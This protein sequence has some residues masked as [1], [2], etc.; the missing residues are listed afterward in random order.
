MWRRGAAELKTEVL[1]RQ[2]RSSL[3]ADRL[4]VRRRNAGPYRWLID[5]NR[6][7]NSAGAF[8]EFREMLRMNTVLLACSTL[9]VAPR[10]V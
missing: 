1:R 4:R 8:A 9:L 7:A 6:P 10:G 5:L 3:R 2:D